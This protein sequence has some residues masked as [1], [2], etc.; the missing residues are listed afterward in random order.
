MNKKQLLTT[1]LEEVENKRLKV[2]EDRCTEGCCVDIEVI[3]RDGEGYMVIDVMPDEVDVFNLAI[4][5]VSTLI[6]KRLER[7]KNE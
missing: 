5:Q 3:D 4:S 1:L 2:V 6:K 7:L